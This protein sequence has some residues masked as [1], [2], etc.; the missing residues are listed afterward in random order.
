MVYL[1]RLPVSV[2]LPARPDSPKAVALAPADD[3]LVRRPEL[4]VVTAVDRRRDS[5]G[6]EGRASID[7]DYRRSRRRANVT[8]AA[9]RMPSLCVTLAALV[10]AAAAQAAGP[11]ASS[12]RF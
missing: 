2:D 10:A 7:R 1:R 3:G 11:P 12:L 8:M 9:M 5:T 6:R 4:P